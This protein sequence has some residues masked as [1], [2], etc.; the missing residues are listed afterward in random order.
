LWNALSEAERQDFIDRLVKEENKH[1][2]STR[3]LKIADFK[4][5][6]KPTKAKK[7][8]VYDLKN[9][10]GGI[11]TYYLQIIRDKDIV[12]NG[13]PGYPEIVIER[14]WQQ[15]LHMPTAVFSGARTLSD[16]QYLI[17]HALLEH[18]ELAIVYVD[19]DIRQ[20]DNIR[21]VTEQ[22]LLLFR[23]DLLRLFEDLGGKVWIIESNCSHEV[24]K[25]NVALVAREIQE[26]MRVT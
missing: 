2:V 13:R 24:Y 22:D 17:E 11:F 18:V 4:V 3:S 20:K 15:S 9:A 7:K 14:Q 12:L 21:G 6:G 1:L 26:F 23:H 5:M 10:F 19:S 25:K 16:F 8:V